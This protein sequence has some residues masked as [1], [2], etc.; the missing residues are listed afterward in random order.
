MKLIRR[1]KL[2]IKKFPDNNINNC[3]WTTVNNKNVLNFNKLIMKADVGRADIKG[4]KG[5]NIN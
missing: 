4:L 1:V 5:K 2:F 3:R